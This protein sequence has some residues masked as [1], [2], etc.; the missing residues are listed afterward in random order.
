ML[1]LATQ[2]QHELLGASNRFDQ[3]RQPKLL[4]LLV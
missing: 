4:H 3:G 1:E 2:R